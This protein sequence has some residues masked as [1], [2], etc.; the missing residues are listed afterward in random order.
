MSEEEF[1]ILGKWKR[2]EKTADGSFTQI[3]YTDNGSC[4]FTISTPSKDEVINLTYYIDNG[5]IVTDQPSHPKIV[6]TPYIITPE[7][8]LV[9]TYDGIVYEYVRL[10]I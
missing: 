6:R 8:I 9:L 4:T 10:L 5:Y 1:K 2:T 7:D 3:E